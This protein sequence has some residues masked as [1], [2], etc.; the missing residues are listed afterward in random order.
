MDRDE[1]RNHYTWAPGTCFQHPTQGT[2]DT[3][4]VKRICPR[5]D[6]EHEIRACRDCVIAMEGTRREAAHRLGSEYAPG[7]VGECDA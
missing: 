5:D 4:V 1:I 2:V 6:G 3:T 7:R